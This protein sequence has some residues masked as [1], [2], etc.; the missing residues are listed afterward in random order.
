MKEA[1]KGVRMTDDEHNGFIEDKPAPSEQ[2]LRPNDSRLVNVDRLAQEIA[3]A[4]GLTKI[5]F[6]HKAMTIANAVFA[7]ASRGE[8]QLYCED[9]PFP[10][11]KDENESM[12]GGLRL[13]SADADALRAFYLDALSDP[14]ALSTDTH[15]PV[16]RSTAQELAILDAIRQLGHDP[17]RLPKNEPGKP[18]IKKQVS[19]ALKR[20]PMFTGSTVF[21]KAWERMRRA[22]DIADVA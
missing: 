2:V 11:D 18:G 17:M 4:M 6:A 22:G 5:E 15:K 12:H 16:Q 9:R 20:S 19:D 1:Q 21:N 13:T 10:F 7:R 14:L 3:R 8:I